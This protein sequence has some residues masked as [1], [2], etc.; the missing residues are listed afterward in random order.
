MLPVTQFLQL[1]AELARGQPL[2]KGCRLQPC[3]EP[4]S[5]WRWPLGLPTWGKPRPRPASPTGKGLGDLLHPTKS[6][7]SQEMLLVLLCKI[8]AAIQRTSPGPHPDP[9]DQ[10]RVRRGECPSQGTMLSKGAE[11]GTLSKRRLSPCGGQQTTCPAG[12]RGSI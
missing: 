2:L 4:P 3:L 9:A 10:T 5:Q 12:K 6:T 8:A 11:Q 1:K 7:V